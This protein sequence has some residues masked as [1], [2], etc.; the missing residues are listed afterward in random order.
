MPIGMFRILSAVILL[1]SATFLPAF[2]FP[3]PAEV[4]R[5]SLQIGQGAYPDADEILLAGIQNLSYSPDGTGDNVDD[6]YLKILTEKGRSDYRTIDFHFNSHYQTIEILV[7]EIIKPDGSIAPIDIAANSRTSVSHHQMGSNIYDPSQKLTTLNLP[8]LEPGDIIHYRFI[9]KT[10]KARMPGTWSEYIVLQS[11]R[12]ILDYKVEIRSPQELPLANFALKDEEK[13]TIEFS[14]GTE[15]AETVHRWH[16]RN[17]PQVFPEPGMPPL[18]TS[19]QRLVVGTV[20]SWED[21]SK[22]YWN[23]CLPHIGKTTQAMRE[24]VDRLCEGR[25]TDEEKARAI[26]DFVSQK[27]RYMGIT[28]EDEAP[29]YEPHDVSITFE[30]RYGVCRDKAALLVAMLRMA[31]LKAYPV[32]IMA[33]PKKEP[34]VPTPFFNHAIGCVEKADGSYILMDATG[35]TEK[36]LLAAYLSDKSYLVA[37]PEGDTLRI[38]P[39]IPASENMLSIETVCEIRRDGSGSG[40]T[41]IAFA[42]INDSAYRGDLLRRNQEQMRDFIETVARRANSE[43]RVESFELLP[44]DLSDT[45]TPLSLSFKFTMPEMLVGNSSSVVLLPPLLSREV[46]M[47]NFLLGKMGLEKRRFP[48]FTEIACGVREKIEMRPAEDSPPLPRFAQMGRSELDTPS[49]KWSHGYRTGHDSIAYDSEFVLKSVEYSPSEYVEL[50]KALGRRQLDLMSFPVAERH[51]GGGTGAP[52]AQAEENG[53]RIISVDSEIEIADAS[54]WTETRTLAAELLD[55]SGKMEISEMKF[56]FN[57]GSAEVKVEYARVV[58][59]DGVVKEIS[60][61]EMNLMDQGWSST[62]PRY[63]AGKILVLSLPGVDIGSR[64]E[65]KT[66]RRNFKR[67]FISF[68]DNL[69]SFNKVLKKRISVKNPN[70]VPLRF[71]ERV[72]G[73]LAEGSVGRDGIER[74]YRDIQAARKEGDI[75]PAWADGDFFALSSGEWKDYA[76]RMDARLRDAAERCR[77]IDKF[78]DIF[79]GGKEPDAIVRAIRDFAAMNIRRAGPS[80]DELPDD[81]QIDAD[82]VLSERYGTSAETAALIGA[83]LGK[84]GIKYDF[85]LCAGTPFLEGRMT[86]MEKCPQS[87]FF[88][89]VL[90]RTEIG[91]RTIYLNDSDQYAELGSVGGEGAAGLAAGG[92]SFFGIKPDSGFESGSSALLMMKIEEDGAALIRLSASFHGMEHA[93][94]KK[95]VSEMTPEYLRRFYQESASSLMISARLAGDAKA[96]FNS[97]PGKLEFTVRC[98]EF[99]KIADGRISF[100]L[101]GRHGF[102]DNMLVSRKNP[103][104][105]GEHS[106]KKFKYVIAVPDAY[107][108]P[109]LI[110]PAEWSAELPSGVSMRIS[111]A[112]EEGGAARDFFGN[113]RRFLV[114]DFSARASSGIFDGGEYASLLEKSSIFNSMRNAVV[115]MK[116]KDR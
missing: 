42:G 98:E 40:E 13:G 22:W 54:S 35:E 52:D 91:G 69:R 96:D 59:K 49:L 94:M 21:I 37:K 97:Y 8:G 10:L 61:A 101:P 17:V 24:E 104:L 15:G 47:A 28:T 71:V 2:E 44:K 63:P 58:S 50:K 68:I 18:Y 73:R 70:A 103:F 5:A 6:V 72:G 115:V 19:V 113:A 4:H 112:I 38:S 75:P 57:E 105:L 87:G 33:G 48:L 9:E 7:A 11:D 55:F 78:S 65:L 111:S 80:F 92:D 32:L 107:E 62:A 20:K 53:Y 26:F 93:K 12:P 102:M 45:A 84:A 76:S 46:G 41:R 25:R 66:A 108:I 64:I 14:S 30:N 1:Y 56:H 82:K 31:G 3:A 51:E 74:T 88:Q 116:K 39:I 77:D 90:L 67:P 23:L 110:P 109:E 34:E 81:F 36:E 43:C 99:A 100:V 60:P 114:V 106:F 86:P 85:V 89:Q 27:V 83:M 16:A 95:G 29:G 79:G